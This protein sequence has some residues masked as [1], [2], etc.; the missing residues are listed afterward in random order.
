[1][2]KT[3]AILAVAVLVLRPP[4]VAAQQDNSPSVK[5]SKR[6]LIVSPYES[7]DVADINRDGQLDIVYDSFWF[8][9][10][11]WLA[12]QIRPTHT[13]SDYIR[14]NSDHVY[15]VDKDGWLDVIAG[16]WTEH[17]IIWFKNLGRVP[18]ERGAPWEVPKPWESQ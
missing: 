16:A 15:D 3:F 12:H 7:C 18:A 5:F 17:G 11:N 1:M 13:S 8:A 9:G 2:A 6:K 14:C 10:P 4:Q